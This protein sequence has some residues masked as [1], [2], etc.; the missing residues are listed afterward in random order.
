MTTGWALNRSLERVRRLG[1][2]LLDHRALRA[3]VLKELGRI[4]PFSA[5]VWPLSDPATATG[6]SPL[7]RVPCPEELPLLI[8]LK[9]LTPM[10]RWTQLAESASPVTSLLQASN[11]EPS[12]SPVWDGVLKRHGVSDVLF[13]VFAG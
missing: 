10:G 3:G 8:R 6:I 7:A 13:T 5:C 2:S 4:L 12:K 1:D 11:G 9:Y